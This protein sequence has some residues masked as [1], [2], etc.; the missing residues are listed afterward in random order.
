MH[1]DIQ[2]FFLTYVGLTTAS[3]AFKIFPM[4]SNKYGKWLLAVIQFALANSEKGQQNISAAGI[5]GKIEDF[6]E[7]NGPS[8]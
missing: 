4:P 3:Y 2:Q 8:N 7:K 6:K 5:Q 1:F